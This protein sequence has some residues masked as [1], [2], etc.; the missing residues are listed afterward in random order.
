MT[1]NG[2]APAASVALVD[3]QT[4]VELHAGLKKLTPE[5]R[6]G[7]LANFGI[8]RVSKLRAEDVDAARAYV[9]GPQGADDDEIPL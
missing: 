4:A 2:D 7:F 1:A 5:E 6:Q 9:A 3:H 8:E